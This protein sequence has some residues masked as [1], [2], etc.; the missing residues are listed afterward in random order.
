MIH[1]LGFRGFSSVA[2]DT[3]FN[4]LEQDRH[5]HTHTHT[6]TYTLTV[7]RAVEEPT[8]THLVARS[9]E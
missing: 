7:Q 8:N 6:H 9:R 1:G 5:A 4:E 3:Q 2:T